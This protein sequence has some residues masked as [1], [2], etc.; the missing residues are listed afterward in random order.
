VSWPPDCAAAGAGDLGRQRRRRDPRTRYEI[1][2]SD[3]PRRRRSAQ[4]TPPD[5]R[6]SLP[7]GTAET[8]PWDTGRDAAGELELV[9]GESRLAGVR[10]AMALRILISRLRDAFACDVGGIEL[11]G[12]DEPPA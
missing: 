10:G 5:V 11:V 8:R 1:P 3:G 2:L 6:R 4:R 7:L 12:A 9:D